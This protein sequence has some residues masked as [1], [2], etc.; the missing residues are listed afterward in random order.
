MQHDCILAENRKRLLKI[1]NAEIVAF[2]ISISSGV[3][4][5]MLDRGCFINLIKRSSVEE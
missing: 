4:K 1:K 5:L 3:L 2:G